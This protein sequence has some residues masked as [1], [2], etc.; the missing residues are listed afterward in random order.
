MRVQRGRMV[1]EL[2][3]GGLFGDFDPKV[4]FWVGWGEVWRWRFDPD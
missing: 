3:N 1:A 2:L 4:E